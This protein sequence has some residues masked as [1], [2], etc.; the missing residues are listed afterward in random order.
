MKPREGKHETLIR[1]FCRFC[2]ATAKACHRVWTNL[3]A[4]ISPLHLSTRMRECSGKSWLQSFWVGGGRHSNIQIVFRLVTMAMCLSR[5][6]PDIVS[7]VLRHCATR[8]LSGGFRRSHMLAKSVFLRYV[9]VT[10]R[11]RG[12]WLLGP[13]VYARA[14]HQQLAST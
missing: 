7:L 1:W 10:I 9:W 4:M 5:V 6:S 11:K 12:S 8:G 2:P 14:L 3:I 13:R